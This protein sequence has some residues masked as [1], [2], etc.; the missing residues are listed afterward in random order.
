MIYFVQAG[1]PSGAIKIGYT[2]TSLKKRVGALQTSHPEKLTILGAIIGAPSD[3][4]A[5]HKRFHAERMEGEWFRPVIDLLE[6]IWSL[7]PFD[8]AA[9]LRKPV[10]AKPQSAPARV[11]QRATPAPGMADLKVSGDNPA[12]AVH[13]WSRYRH[14]LNIER[15]ERRLHADVRSWQFVPEQHLARFCE[16]TGIPSRQIRPDLFEPKPPKPLVI[17]YGFDDLPQFNLSE[18]LSEMENYQ[19]PIPQTNNLFFSQMLS[20]TDGSK[21][22]FPTTNS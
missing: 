18:Y 11:V 13:A 7:P 9:A 10:P 14:G 3:E 17:G 1:P 6:L 16:L 5:L 12:K 22:T 20:L 15:L 2:S 8:E 4:K 19:W 21:S